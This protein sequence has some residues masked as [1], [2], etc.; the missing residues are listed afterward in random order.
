MMLVSEVMLVCVCVVVVVVVVGGCIHHNIPSYLP[1]PR[2][3]WMFKTHLAGG[4][5]QRSFLAVW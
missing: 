1:N 4:F 2:L 3:S 5:D